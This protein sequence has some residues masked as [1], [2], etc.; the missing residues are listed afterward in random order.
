MAWCPPPGAAAAAGHL[1]GPGGEAAGEPESDQEA[2]GCR[3]RLPQGGGG[4]GGGGPQPAG[5]PDASGQRPGSVPEEDAWHRRVNIS[6]SQ[7]T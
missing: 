1:P 6:S 2:G 4:G 3:G 5:Q 7:Q